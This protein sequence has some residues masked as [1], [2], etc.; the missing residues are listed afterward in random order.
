MYILLFTIVHFVFCLVF[1]RY[2]QNL[3][4]IFDTPSRFWEAY[5]GLDGKAGDPCPLTLDIQATKL[6]MWR[7]KQLIVIG[8]PLPIPW[9]EVAG[10]VNVRDNGEKL[11]ILI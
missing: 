6:N 1:A 8:N 7:E 11:F 2:F 3:P 4:Y 10:K 9:C 5:S